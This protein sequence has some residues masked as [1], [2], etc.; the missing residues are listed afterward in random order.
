MSGLASP[1]TPSW[2]PLSLLLLFGVRVFPVAFLTTLSLSASGHTTGIK[3]MLVNH[4]VLRMLLGTPR[5][6]ESARC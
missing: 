5:L 2:V 3:V 6:T 4:L 1:L